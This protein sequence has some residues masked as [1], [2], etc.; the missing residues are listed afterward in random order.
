[1]KLELYTDSRECDVLQAEWDTLVQRSVSNVLFM[2]WGWQC[3]WWE[4]FGT[5]KQLRLLALRDNGGRLAAVAPLFAQD[6]F[7]DVD[8]V[9]P[10]IH[11]EHPVP[12]ANGQMRRTLHL[13]GG[14]EVSD[15][16]DIVAPADHH[17]EACL[18]LVEALA[19][20]SDWHV[21]DL[22]CLPT[23]SPTLAT[24]S[25]LARA[26]GWGVQQAREDVCPVLELPG[27]WAEYLTLKLNKKQ[28]HELRRKIRR[29]EQ[30]TQVEWHWANDFVSLE[31]ALD[32]FFRLHKTS[33]PGKEVFMDER[34]Q[35]FFRAVARFA[36]QKGWLRLSTLTFNNQPVASYVCFDY[37]GDRLVYNSGFDLS[38]YSDLAPGVVLV[39]YMI[40]E[41]I[42]R[43]L[44]RFDFLQGNE[45][46][47]YDFGASD[48]EVMR[49]LVRR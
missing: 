34:M 21:L 26:R 5:G 13:V 19:S 29:A 16:L 24:V 3:A 42:Q 49:L 22:R 23:G 40:E 2:T 18:S 20:Q 27:T 12:T 11:V 14:T 48:T 45:R 30:E 38:A 35:G 47:K 8:A 15:Y 41:A 33:D 10:E 31:P 28:R 46:Y 39:G 4:A 1:M 7:M 37:A 44:R 25:E 17:R 36:L 43:R 32:T 9:L 6:T